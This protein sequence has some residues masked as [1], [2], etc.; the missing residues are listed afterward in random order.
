MLSRVGSAPVATTS[1]RLKL[2]YRGKS[3]KNEVGCRYICNSRKINIYVGQKKGGK[4][5]CRIE[6]RAVPNSL[7]EYLACPDL[8][9][10]GGWS[11]PITYGS[12]VVWNACRAYGAVP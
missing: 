10:A 6:I 7:T 8:W 4:C 11:F 2:S 12:H 3:Q 9:I 5:D 1:Y